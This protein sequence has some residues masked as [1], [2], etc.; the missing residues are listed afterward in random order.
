MEIVD[1]SGVE[2]LHPGLWMSSLEHDVA[3]TIETVN[4]RS[5]R[6]PRMSRKLFSSVL[7]YAALCCVVWVVV[8]L[9]L[10]HIHNSRLFV[11]LKGHNQILSEVPSNILENC[12]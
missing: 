8:Q 1:W 4:I 7:C 9:P 5:Q 3:I 11:Q 6:L 10:V 2:F 12:S